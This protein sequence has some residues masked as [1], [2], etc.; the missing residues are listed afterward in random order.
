MDSNSFM[1]DF[2]QFIKYDENLFILKKK[3]EV[4]VSCHISGLVQTNERLP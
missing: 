4:H 2:V 1:G 3:I